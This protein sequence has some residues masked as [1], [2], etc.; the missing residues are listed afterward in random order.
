MDEILTQPS[1]LHN[2]LQLVLWCRTYT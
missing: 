1:D 2:I